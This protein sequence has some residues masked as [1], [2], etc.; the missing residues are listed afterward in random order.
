MTDITEAKAMMPAVTS[1]SGGRVLVKF[2]TTPSTVG[3]NVVCN[4]T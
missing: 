4:T 2:E 1:N 3:H